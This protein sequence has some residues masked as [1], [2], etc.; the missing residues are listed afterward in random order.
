MGE[1]TTERR[2]RA[3]NLIRSSEVHLLS[4]V[5]RHDT[6]QCIVLV[7]SGL[8]VSAQVQS[9]VVGC[10]ASSVESFGRGVALL[11]EASHHSRVPYHHESETITCTK[12]L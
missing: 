11:N 6:T 12:M 10:S 9:E 4:P 5:T 2:H 3:L 7:V 1:P 8:F